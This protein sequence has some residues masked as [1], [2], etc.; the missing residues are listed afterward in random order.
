MPSLNS[1]IR[2]QN[3]V[4]FGHSRND[5]V[6]FVIC[7]A[8]TDAHIHLN[9]LRQLTMLLQDEARVKQMR[10]GDKQTLLRLVDQV[11]QL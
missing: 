2:L 11:S 5:P 6:S 9:A 4:S 1:F 7:L 3:P 10:E 8:T